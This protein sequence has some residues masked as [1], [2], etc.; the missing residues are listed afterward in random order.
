MTIFLIFYL[1][2]SL[3]L[4]TSESESSKKRKKADF[5]I[6]IENHYH[7]AKT[8]AHKD[9]DSED[10]DSDTLNVDMTQLEEIEPFDIPNYFSEIN[11]R[12]FPSARSLTPY[13][14]PVDTPEQE[15]RYQR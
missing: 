9:P 2:G 1:V 10:Y 6:D 8:Q 11:G 12:L 4:M 14:F 7:M 5:L 13:P 15:V 3:M